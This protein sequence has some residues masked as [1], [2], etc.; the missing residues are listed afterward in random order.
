MIA[1]SFDHERLD[2]YRLTIEYVAVSFEASESLDGRHPGR[3]V[4]DAG[5]SRFKT[6]LP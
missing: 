4:G 3:A 2:V 5:E 6:L 1:H